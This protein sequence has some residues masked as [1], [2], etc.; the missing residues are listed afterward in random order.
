MCNP[1][2]IVGNSTRFGSGNNRAVPLKSSR[3]G[4]SLA[5]AVH[6]K[7]LFL[8]G[9]ERRPI[10]PLGRRRL[11][12][13]LGDQFLVQLGRR[14]PVRGGQRLGETFFHLRPEAGDV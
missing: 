1:W 3:S 14:S 9:G 10:G 11:E 4:T 13:D 2:S 7:G 8:V 6:R 12:F 5:M